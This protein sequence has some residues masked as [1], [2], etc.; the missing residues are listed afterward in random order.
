VTEPRGDP[1]AA[2]DALVADVVG[3]AG[4]V[5]AGADVDDGVV[6]AGAL[7]LDEPAVPVAEVPLTL[8]LQAAH[9]RVPKP[10]ASI[11]RRSTNGRSGVTPT[12]VWPVPVSSRGRP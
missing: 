8:E 5:V 6:D 10:P 4:S 12:T 1:P 7:V 11:I 2:E 9:S 3:A